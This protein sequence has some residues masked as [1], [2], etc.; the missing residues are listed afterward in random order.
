MYHEYDKK[1]QKYYNEIVDFSRLFD[2]SE[3]S[4]NETN[5]A[6]HDIVADVKSADKQKYLDKYEEMIR[7][8]IG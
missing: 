6:C 3:N 1:K 2:E 7:K 5:I 4:D 8:Y